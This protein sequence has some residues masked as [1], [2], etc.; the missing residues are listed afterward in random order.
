[1]AIA[2]VKY[3]TRSK[4]RAAADYGRVAVSLTRQGHTVTSVDRNWLQ[5]TQSHGFLLEQRILFSPHATRALGL[6][7]ALRKTVLVGVRVSHQDSRSTFAES[8]LSFRVSPTRVSRA[9]RGRVKATAAQQSQQGYVTTTGWPPDAIYYG[10]W[11][12]L[13]AGIYWLGTGADEGPPYTPYLGAVSPG[14]AENWICADTVIQPRYPVQDGFLQPDGTFQIANALG[15]YDRNSGY[16]CWDNALIIGKVVPSPTR[17]A[18][19]VDC[20]T[21]ILQLT[22]WAFES[23]TPYTFTQAPLTLPCVGD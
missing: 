5:G 2:R 3:Q 9:N 7:G 18:G 21:A 17:P 6:R 16:E 11:T 22:G 20:A 10:S 14:L 8:R 12:G 1:M 15:S 4:L 23:G 13:N 19:S